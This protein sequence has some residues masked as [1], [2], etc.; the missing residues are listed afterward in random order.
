MIGVGSLVS[1][2]VVAED[3]NVVYVDLFVYGLFNDVSVM[4][5]MVGSVWY[6]VNWKDMEGDVCGM[7]CGAIPAFVWRDRGNSQKINVRISCL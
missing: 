5:C 6:V 4:Q 1:L 2:C 3:W 7:I